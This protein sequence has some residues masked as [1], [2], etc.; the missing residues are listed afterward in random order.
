MGN[1]LASQGGLFGNMG[2]L[3]DQVKKAQQ[4]VQ[5]EAV[6]VQKELAACVAHAPAAIPLSSAADTH[7][8]TRARAHSAEF[9]GYSSDEL[10]K[11][12]VSGNQARAHPACLV[13]SAALTR[14]YMR[15]VRAGA[16]RLRHHRGGDGAR[17]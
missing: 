2:A 7:T 3:M 12:L 9:E 13:A 11:A 15:G 10:V 14:A 5:V 16:A 8:H 6:K 4:V 17:R 1:A